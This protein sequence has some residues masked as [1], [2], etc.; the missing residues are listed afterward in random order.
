MVRT[1]GFNRGD[2]LADMILVIVI[3][4]IHKAGYLHRDIS[5]RNIILVEE[6][7]SGPERRGFLIDYDYCINF[8]QDREAAMG[9]RTVSVNVFCPIGYDYH[10]ALTGDIS[11]HG[12]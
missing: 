12:S 8:L 2:F 11:V 7:G 6:D 5:L 10:S 3:D 4:E 1:Y 9:S